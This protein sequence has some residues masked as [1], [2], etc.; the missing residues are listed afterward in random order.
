MMNRKNIE[1]LKLNIRMCIWEILIS[2]AAFLIWLIAEHI[3]DMPGDNCEILMIIIT[4]FMWIR[5]VRKLVS[6]NMFE[7]EAYLYQSLPVSYVCITF[8]KVGLGAAVLFPLMSFFAI[9]KR[10]ENALWQQLAEGLLLAVMF[11]A[12]IYIIQ[13]YGRT[14]HKEK[15]NPCSRI[16]RTCNP[17]NYPVSSGHTGDTGNEHVRCGSHT[18]SSRHTACR[19]S[20]KGDEALVCAV[21]T[22][23]KA[24]RNR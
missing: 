21:V 18:G 12:L 6:R 14:G 19:R 11:S 13:I 10:Q 1:Y 22:G 2:L 16:Y 17:C 20:G 3:F 23:E 4:A 8:T 15:K 9:I 24:G 7:S 5:T